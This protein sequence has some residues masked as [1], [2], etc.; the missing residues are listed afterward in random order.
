MIIPLIL[1]LRSSGMALAPRVTET[2][3]RSP[4]VARDRENEPTTA[5][6]QRDGEERILLSC[7]AALHR[8][9]RPVEPVLSE[10]R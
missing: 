4:A 2:Q 9:K 8:L 7:E 3:I 6:G 5:C 1:L 10:P